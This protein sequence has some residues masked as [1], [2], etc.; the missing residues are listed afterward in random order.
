MDYYELNRKNYN[1]IRSILFS[2]PEGHMHIHKITIKCGKF[3]VDVALSSSTFVTEGIWIYRPHL[4]SFHITSYQ[5]RVKRE[6]AELI[7]EASYVSV[8]SEYTD[9]ISDED[10]SILISSLVNLFD[11]VD[12]GLTKRAF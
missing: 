2:L 12:T 5:P 7:M 3:N 1:K 6:I 8:S 11:P 4:E 9:Q 10:Q